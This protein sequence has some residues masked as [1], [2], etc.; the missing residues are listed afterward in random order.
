MVRAF[1]IGY[2]SKK[3]F[4]IKHPKINR[5]L[6]IHFLILQFSIDLTFDT[7]FKSIKLYFSLYDTPVHLILRQ[8]TNC[9]YKIQFNKRKSTSQ[10]VLHLYAIILDALAHNTTL[11]HF[12][13]LPAYFHP[14]VPQ[15]FVQ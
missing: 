5:L 4:S 3:L 14:L 8:N 6:F 11:Y 9:F 2:C 12:H 15:Y 1:L 10:K 7:Q 13:P